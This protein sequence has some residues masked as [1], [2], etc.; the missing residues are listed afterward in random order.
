MDKFVLLERAIQIAT[1]AH[2]GQEDRQGKPYILHV[3]RVM[4]KGQTIDEQTCGALHDVVEDTDWTFDSLR[5]EGFPEHILEAV[6]CLTRRDDEDYDAFIE[7]IR[8]NPL[9]V[10]VKLNDLEDNMD[11]RRAQQLS[12]KDLTRYNKYIKAYHYLTP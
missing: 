8:P 11:L 3:L 4:A 10:R 12:E 9:A 1:Q 2:A 5:K 7:R 6:D